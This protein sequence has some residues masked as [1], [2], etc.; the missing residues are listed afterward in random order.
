MPIKNNSIIDYFDYE[1]DQ[2]LEER[3]DLKSLRAYLTLLRIHLEDLLSVMDANGN[4]ELDKPVDLFGLCREVDEALEKLTK[5]HPAL[6][7]LEGLIAS[8]RSKVSHGVLESMYEQ[9][10]KGLS[11]GSFAANRELTNERDLAKEMLSLTP[12]MRSEDPEVTINPN[13]V[14]IHHP[15]QYASIVRLI[16]D[17]GTG[18][19]D[20]KK[21]KDM[22]PGDLEGRCHFVRER[23]DEADE[24][25][26]D[27]IRHYRKVSESLGP[28]FLAD[29]LMASEP[30][31]AKSFDHSLK[32]ISRYLGRTSKRFPTPHDIADLPAVSLERPAL[33]KVVFIS[34]R[35][36]VY[37]MLTESAGEAL[38]PE[39]H[40]ERLNEVG[41]HL[42]ET[43]DP[44]QE[45]HLSLIKEIIEYFETALKLPVSDR[46][47]KEVYDHRK[48]K[49][50]PVPSLRQRIAM[51]EIEKEKT[52]LLAFFMG[53]GKTAS[54][55]LCKEHVGAKKMLF[56][57]TN[58]VGMPK[59]V[60]TQVE[61]HY[62][63]GEAPTV[64][65][66]TAKA[67]Q[68]EITEALESEIIIMP[69]SMLT[70]KER[71]KGKI[72]E[73]LY[74][75]GIDFLTVDEVQWAKNKQGL[76]TEEVRK[77]TENIP[78][79]EYKLLLSG[80]PVPNVPDDILPQ[81][82]LKK[83]DEFTPPG[84]KPEGANQDEYS[85][86]KMQS[87]RYWMRQNDPLLLRT[88][89]LDF[90]LKLDLPGEWESY[91][92][93]VPLKLSPAQQAHYD[94]ILANDEL[95]TMEKINQL[96][97]ALLN[98]ALGSPM[99]T[100]NATLDAIFDIVVKD[101]EDND[102]VVIAIDNFRRGILDRKLE[103]ELAHVP[104]LME[105]L[106]E[107]LEAHFGEGK[108][109][110]HMIH[111]DVPIEK[112]PD[113][114]DDVRYPP[115]GQKVVLFSLLDP[116]K[117]GINLSE[118]NR[119]ILL[120]PTMRKADMAQFVKR[121]ARDGNDEA[122]IRVLGCQDTIFQ[123]ID[124]HS[125]HKYYLCQRL[126]HGGTLTD[127]DMAVLE[128]ESINEDVSIQNGKLV[129]GTAIS[130][131]AM[132]DRQTMNMY[133]R[134]LQNRG[135]GRMSLFVDAYGQDYA[136]RYVRNWEGSHSANNGRF[137]AG[138]IDTLFRQRL[139]P[140]GRFADVAC[141]PLVLEN[142]YALMNPSAMIV[143]FDMNP[144]VMD[145]GVE[146]LRRR[147]NNSTYT[148]TKKVSR[149]TGLDA[150]DAAFSLVN[151][152]S[153]LQ[154]LAQGRGNSKTSERSAALEE[155]NRV[156]VNQGVALIT[157]PPN[158]CSE[159]EF[160]TFVAEMENFGFEV[161]DSYTGEGISTDDEEGRVFHN[162]VLAMKK[163]GKP[164]KKQIKVSNLRFTRRHIANVNKGNRSKVRTEAW[165]SHHTEFAINQTP[166]TY[167]ASTQER[168]AKIDEIEYQ[169][170]VNSA[171]TQLVDVYSQNGN[172][173]DDLTEEQKAALA[174][175]GILLIRISGI[176]G[177]A[178]WL[179][180]V[181]N[182]KF[183]SDVSHRLFEELND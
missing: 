42:T 180:S 94:S 84:P 78:G 85:T 107:R 173:L 26:I 125:T 33:R 153:A 57:C 73:Q 171:R 63:D 11:Y 131:K 143:N 45:A 160:E 100:E 110:F 44:S 136:E 165:S 82:R 103:M 25:L 60:A 59:T 19:L 133:H 96:T 10:I 98:P 43:L 142:T 150:E 120:G 48:D 155:I 18:I 177:D 81:L 41:R 86:R 166:L 92:E 157:L 119:A 4:T 141:G 183:K 9:K 127:E 158:V 14:R 114:L 72:T 3:K 97:L 178:K 56:I 121:F 46:I 118:I 95:E 31:I 24:R 101:F 144:F 140:K 130:R 152:A 36:Y 117:E 69:Y 54:A 71:E 181:R 62:K 50:C 35:N 169:R 88:F 15:A 123:G 76:Y 58:G 17:R 75:A 105:Q 174:E 159:V 29:L 1:S 12:Y 99:A 108:V 182:Q 83:P 20:W 137:V 146:M 91:V 65:I 32:I 106:E 145:E 128:G 138:L 124:E 179:F 162:L 176:E 161:L 93:R 30:S 28:E 109:D 39:E 5:E 8:I 66:I 154:C 37:Q 80:D 61:K 16:E 7:E 111:G 52:M 112:R 27:Q 64:G 139:V 49:N 115:S 47:K 70:S 134:H 34:L 163:I 129:I 40:K 175:A 23:A 116:I 13:W 87:L 67:C 132:N 126:L 2:I 168:L 102:S 55:F 167:K 170:L 135:E 21:V 104:S 151:C 172:S 38:S 51:S 147:K 113:I 90:V 89:L 148:P 6:Q 122:K 79:L 149:M 74:K 156:L 77:F 164:K 22:M 68:E 53:M